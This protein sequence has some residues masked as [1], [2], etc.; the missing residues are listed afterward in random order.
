MTDCDTFLFKTMIR[1]IFLCSL[2]ILALTACQ[3]KPAAAA[4]ET[5][6]D[7]VPTFCA[8]SA[9]HT[10]KAQC[11]FGPRIMNSEAHDKCGEY[12]AQKFRDYGAE[13]TLQQADARGWDGTV[14]HMTNIIASVNPKA[15]SRILICAHWDSRPWA[16]NDPDE[17]NHK[18]PI[19]GANDG[20][21]GVSVML[22]LA[23]QLQLKQPAIGVDFICFDAE[24]CGVPTWANQDDDNSWCLGS[25]Y[26]SANP[27]KANY[28][29][30]YGVLLDMVGGQGA[31]FYQEGFSKRYA[32]NIVNKVWQAA[33]D[34]GYAGYFPMEDGG[35][36]TD[37]HV[38]MN[39]VARIPTVDIIPYYPNGNS[40]FGP[41]WHTVNDTP[42]NIDAA[43]LNAV[44][45]TMMQL[46]YQEK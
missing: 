38:P 28:K 13:V 37:D 5:P 44:G 29:P 39:E 8:D 20:A 16:D 3:Q 46:I 9:M 23:R 41:T 14:Y 31:T 26:W 2:L 25:Q 40:S 42:E 12:I 11:A 36:V 17:K 18:T 43:T 4:E 22:E 33:R 21:S 27:H 32:Q 7:S 30:R 45:Q 35:Y 24:D 10:L 15:A 6:T 1:P 19:L 34:A